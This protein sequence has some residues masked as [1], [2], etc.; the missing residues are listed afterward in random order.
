MLF[1]LAEFPWL[2]YFTFLA[3][4]F[5]IGRMKYNWLF[6]G[7]DRIIPS[8]PFLTYQGNTTIIIVVLR[9]GVLHFSPSQPPARCDF[10]ASGG[11]FVF[12]FALF[13]IRS[14]YCSVCLELTD[15]PVSVPEGL[16]WKAYATTQQFSLLLYSNFCI[17]IYL[18]C[19]NMYRE[20]RGQN[21]S[22]YS[23][24]THHVASRDWI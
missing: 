13:E 10:P 18:V 21:R 6:H 17:F 12:V 2:N 9:Q 16:G 4:C 24:P 15:L 3:S 1:L 5:H 8:V 20:V 7:L 11:R 19:V 23:T 22:Q 14:Y